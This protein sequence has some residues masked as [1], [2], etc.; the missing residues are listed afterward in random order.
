MELVGGARRCR[1][2]APPRG[3]SGKRCGT[4]KEVLRG[5]GCCVRAYCRLRGISILHRV[6]LVGFRW[7][8][9]LCRGFRSH[10]FDHVVGIRNLDFEGF[11][12]QTVDLARENKELKRANEILKAAAACLWVELDR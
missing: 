6:V 7:N 1:N 9:W 4:Q 8:I 12:G 10:V 2:S 11:V 3:T 5:L